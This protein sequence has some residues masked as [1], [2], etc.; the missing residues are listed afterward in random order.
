MAH[1]WSVIGQSYLFIPTRYGVPGNGLEPARPQRSG[2]FKCLAAASRYISLHLATAKTSMTRPIFMYWGA[3]GCDGC[4]TYLSLE[5]PPGG[6]TAVVI[7][8]VTAQIH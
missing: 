7:V 8:M 6:L 2:D 1:E 3:V 4:V 5:H